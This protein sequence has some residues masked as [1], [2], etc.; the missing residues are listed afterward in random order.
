MLKQLKAAMLVFAC[1][2]MALAQTPGQTGKYAEIVLTLSQYS[3]ARSLALL[4][5]SESFYFPELDIFNPDGELVYGR[6]HSI[7]NARILR[8][9]PSILKNPHTADQSYKLSAFVKALPATQQNRVAMLV[10]ARQ[11]LLFSVLLGQCA[12]CEAQEIALDSVKQQLLD[13]GISIL[14]IHVVLSGQ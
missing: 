5:G 4:N 9:L 11:P 1:S 3:K 13:Q 10:S 8:N 2:S 7:E 14:I 6:N 12:G